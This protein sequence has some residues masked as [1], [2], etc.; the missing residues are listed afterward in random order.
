M[1]R[2]GGDTT[3]LRVFRFDP[4]LNE[5][6]VY[7]TYTVPL[8]GSVLDGL[9]YILENYDG[10]L[11]FR[12][13]C[14]G[15]GY[16]RCGACAILVDGSPAFGC[17]MALQGGD[18]TIEPHP[19]FAVIKDLAIDFDREQ[20][21]KRKR[22]KPLGRIVIDAEKCVGCRD[23]VLLCP[24]NVL[25]IEKTGRK[26]KATVADPDSC[27]GTTCKMCVAYCPQGAMRMEPVKKVRRR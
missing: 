19:K 2:K 22:T 13:G 21:G 7:K 17:K 15:P 23:C 11:S 3:E 16:E 12:F 5:R 18:M 20:A 27:C 9:R 8:N 14:S 1:N 25:Q 10:S 24:M 6:P 26:G 4:D